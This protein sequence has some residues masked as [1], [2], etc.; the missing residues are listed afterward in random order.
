MALSVIGRTVLFD[1]TT[2]SGYQLSFLAFAWVALVPVPGGGSRETS[3]ARLLLPLLAVLQALHA[4]PVAGSQV[5]WSAFLLI[6]VGALCVSNGVRGLA[7]AL[8]IG[9]ERRGILAIGAAAAAIAMVVLVNIQLRHPLDEAR[10][11][12]D[13]SVSLGLPGATDVRLGAP[14]AQLYGEVV[15][16]I[17]S[18][19]DAF[20]MLPGMNSF[21]IWTEQEPPT[22]YN[23]T[24]WPTLF[25]DAHQRHVIEDTR[26]IA[27]LCLLRN[28]P[29]AEGW[30]EGKIPA[31]PLVRYLKQGFKP[32]ATFGDYELLK[33]Y[34][35][36]GRSS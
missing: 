9:S 1:A 7:G 15:A 6:P 10:A 2:F 16:A 12:Y 25:D 32:V 28:I 18:H 24:G 11:A 4:F 14:E 31:G 21:Y 20:L 3:F 35:T 8:P 29:L 26:S 36:A 17:D 27:G 33:R 23:A 34:G 30:G 5:L 13:G 19:C 22:G